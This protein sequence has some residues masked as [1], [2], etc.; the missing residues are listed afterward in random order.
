MKATLIAFLKSA[1]E[2]FKEKTGT[3]IDRIEVTGGSSQVP[4][5]ITAIEEFTATTAT[6]ALPT[7]LKYTLNSIEYLA[8]GGC[9]MDMCL[10]NW[11][12]N[13]S[14]AA[15]F[16]M[17]YYPPC[18]FENEKDFK[19][20]KGSYRL[21]VAVKDNYKWV[22]KMITV[23]ESNQEM[24][25]AM[26]NDEPVMKMK[27][28]CSFGVKNNTSV[29]LMNPSKKL[30]FPEMY[31]YVH[32][33]AYSEE[34]DVEVSVRF[35]VDKNG[36]PH[37]IGEDANTQVTE[38][39]VPVNANTN[40]ASLRHSVEEAEKEADRITPEN[41]NSEDWSMLARVVYN[42]RLCNGF[43]A[44]QK[45]IN[46]L[47]NECHVYQNAHSA[48]FSE[49]YSEQI[50]QVIRLLVNSN[51]KE[52]M[53]RVKPRLE[54]MAADDKHVKKYTEICTEMEKLYASMLL[55]RIP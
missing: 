30:K 3:V 46:A 24:T 17:G 21:C 11:K 8:E 5:F 52:D 15:F 7:E 4:V 51:K 39:Y 55:N 43:E 1:V 53:E 54:N 23:W 36:I 38:Y 22:E 25:Y 48:E 44:K 45:E 10:R 49:N 33:P 2:D 16:S 31:F 41:V 6:V 29:A 26:V 13:V 34:E 32:N 40:L 19:R 20:T 35:C 50:E 18:H 12:T 42:T 14:P 47:K 9:L 28:A 37:I 27:G